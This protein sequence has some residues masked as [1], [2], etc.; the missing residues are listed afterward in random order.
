MDFLKNIYVDY[1]YR[2]RLKIL[3]VK[4]P[5][6]VSLTTTAPRIKFV[7]QCIKSLFIQEILPEKIV[8]WIDE[9]IKIPSNL[10][11]LLKTGLFIIKTV[12]DI[13]PHTK[14]I[15]ALQSY[16]AKTI[17]TVD[18]DTIYP[19][20]WLIRLYRANKKFPRKIICMAAQINSTF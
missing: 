7:H 13:G 3:K 14:L 2:K 18:D 20:D 10:R 5:I 8:L 1:R 4:A 16:P 9:K 11:E 15:Y 17:I 12:P 19:G 6:I